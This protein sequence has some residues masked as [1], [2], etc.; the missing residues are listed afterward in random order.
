MNHSDHPQPARL[1]K[2]KQQCRLWRSFCTHVATR[3]YWCGGQ[4][5]LPQLNA[6][7]HLR[8]VDSKE[9]TAEGVQWG[10]EYGV[11]EP[12]DLDLLRQHGWR[13][14]NEVF[15]WR[16]EDAPEAKQTL[17]AVPAVAS[18]PGLCLQLDVGAFTVQLVCSIP[19]ATLS[20]PPASTPTPPPLTS[21]PTATCPG[22]SGGGGQLWGTA[23]GAACCGGAHSHWA[24]QQPPAVAA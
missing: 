23:P 7:G 8:E 14:G 21:P 13:V 9:G 15:R 6:V 20:K 24:L 10:A 11:L 4:H 22:A 17:S 1:E 18:R 16:L 19:G 5:T 12:L 2:Q 3:Q